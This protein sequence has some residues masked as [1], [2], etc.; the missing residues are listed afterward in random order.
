MKLEEMM[1]FFSPS[2]NEGTYVDFNNYQPNFYGVNNSTFGNL[3]LQ[4][5]QPQ[6]QQQ[7]QLPTYVQPITSQ[8]YN[9]QPNN[10]F[11]FFQNQVENSNEQIEVEEENCDEL[12]SIKY[13]EKELKLQFE[14][15]KTNILNFYDRVSKVELPELPSS[16]YTTLKNPK[17]KNLYLSFE[18]LDNYNI[19]NVL[20]DGNCLYRAISISLFGTEKYHILLRL[21]LIKELSNEKKFYIQLLK[22]MNINYLNV[23]KST[24]ELKTWGTEVHIFILSNALKRKIVLYDGYNSL[25]SFHQFSF[26][27]KKIENQIL[28]IHWSN[29]NH[30]HFNSLLPMI[31]DEHIDSSIPN[32]G[33]N[34]INEIQ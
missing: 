32:Y 25:K 13:H 7:Q 21:F 24:L 3:P 15:Y 4:F 20:S 22:K 16:S 34:V 31:Y 8:N 6:V 10:F 12:Y 1:N 30:V 19:F 18:L 14:L 9:Y 33:E 27:P 11:N 5:F 17:Q 23:L 28:R 2:T 29:S 26:I